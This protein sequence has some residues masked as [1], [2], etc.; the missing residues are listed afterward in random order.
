VIGTF[1]TG[2]E[3]SEV[4]AD[5]E[6]VQIIGPQKSV[7]AVEN[8]TTDPIDVSGLLGRTTVL[9]HAYVA[10]PLIQVANSRPVRITIIMNRGEA[11]P[12]SR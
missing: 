7:E 5:P 10:D 2:Y 1:A 3:I 11:T 4:Q 6:S 8:A 12:Q 9:R